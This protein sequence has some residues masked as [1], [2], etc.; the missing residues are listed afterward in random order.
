MNVASLIASFSTGTYTVTRTARGST[1][2]GKTAAGTT[3]TVS[4]VAA[5]WPATGDDLK[6]LPEGRRTSE[7]LNLM[8]ATELYAGG[9]GD[10]YEADT[11]S[12]RGESWEVSD[13]D[14]WTDPVSGG[15]GYKCLVTAIR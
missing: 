8:T 12:I 1:V 3:S 10:A 6:R 4:V 7:A 2:K 9:Q 15:L 13:V 5:A 14:T 11:V